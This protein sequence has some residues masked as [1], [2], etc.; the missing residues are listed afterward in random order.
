MGIIR[1]AVNHCEELETGSKNITIMNDFAKAQFSPKGNH[2][3]ISA[4]TLIELLVVIAII[5]ILA[6]ILFP[7]FARARE[8]ARRS[9]CQSNLKQIGLAVI[10]YAQD[11]DESMISY[12]AG[13]GSGAGWVSLVQPYVKSYQVYQCPSE[14]TDYT[15]ASN[16]TDYGYN[17]AFGI[18]PAPPTAPIYPQTN[19]AAITQPTRTVLACDFITRNSANWSNGN[20]NS[21]GAGLTAISTG[22]ARFGPGVGTRHLEGQNFLFTDGHVKWQK[23][24]ELTATVTQSTTVHAVGDCAESVLNG[25][26]TFCYN[27]Q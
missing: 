13:V 25:D 18:Y 23:G 10:Q 19:L 16:I 26:P 5:A 22:L 7:V 15:S 24:R 4:F 2:K 8:N 9:S 14:E 11:Y 21:A 17:I 1:L 12:N 20:V 3:K 6:S 27:I